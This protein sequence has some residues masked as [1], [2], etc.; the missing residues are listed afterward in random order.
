MESSSQVLKLVDE[1]EEVDPSLITINGITFKMLKVSKL[2]V[3]DASR[4]IKIPKPPVVYLEEKSRSEENPSDPTYQE[5]KTEAEYA[6]SMLIMH[7]Y[8]ALGTKPVIIPPEIESIESNDWLESLEEMEIEHP[9]SARV[10]YLLWVK[11]VALP[12]EKDLNDL[13]TA[14]MRYSGITLEGDT[15]AAADGFRNNESGN[16]N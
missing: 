8:I 6:R 4:K 10:R 12:D 1:I 13:I 16:T 3:L 7:A 5:E 11:Y 9:K 15:K 2:L 14:V